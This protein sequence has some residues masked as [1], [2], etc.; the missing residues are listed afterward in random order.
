MHVQY[1]V[2]CGLLE[3]IEHFQIVVLIFQYASKLASKLIE[4]ILEGCYQIVCGG[5]RGSESHFDQCMLWKILH[6]CIPDPYALSNRRIFQFGE[7]YL[8]RLCQC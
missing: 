7:L 3:A 5:N 6:N 1:H 4:L 2:I 8:T